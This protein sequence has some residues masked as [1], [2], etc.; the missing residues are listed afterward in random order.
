MEVVNF[1]NLVAPLSVE[2]FFQKYWGKSF[3][4]QQHDQFDYF[5]KILTP[6]DIDDFLSRQNLPA[7]GIKLVNKG[8][9]VP[10]DEWTKSETLLDGTR[11]V[12][13][14]PEKVFKLFNKGATIIINSA[15]KA[16]PG[17]AN[18]CRIFEQEMKIRVQANI[19][20]TPSH[21]Q[22]FV[23]HYDPHDIFLMQIKGP[24]TWQIY[25]A[26]E[27]LPTNCHSFKNEP[28]LVSKFEMNTGDFLY[29]PRGTI[30][31]AFSSDVSVIHV[32][33]SCKP[34]YGFHL[35]QDLA[36]LAEHE[37][38][39][40]R[41]TIPR[42]LNNHDEI[43]AYVTT[44]SRKLYEL[45]EK[46]TVQKLL[47]MQ[48]EDFVANQ[49]IDFRGSLLNLLQLES[50]NLNS[51]VERRKGFTYLTKNTGAE[52]SISF[53]GSMLKIPG[54]IDKDIFL[55]DK[56]FEVNEIT[57]LVTNQGKLTIVREF[58]EAGFLQIKSI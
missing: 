46:T 27:Q 48:H 50:L 44:F 1:A 41:Y 30:H 42:D 3:V 54:F 13:V 12:V 25:D 8:E 33:F 49:I 29:L 9:K 24:K 39:F 20:I 4:H 37:N 28:V 47:E 17:L 26:G 19:Y 15:H 10:P 45:L 58:V 2:D 53:G 57:G 38:E 55:Q 22:G 6:A 5:K 23:K 11:T 7:D 18:A 14:N 16:I 32:N 34:R 21:S 51:V 56:P 35:L 40:F 36:K 52:F 31:E 43:E